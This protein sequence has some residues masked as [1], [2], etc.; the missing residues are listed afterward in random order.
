M[1]EPFNSTNNTKQSSFSDPFSL[2]AHF[3]PKQAIATPLKGVSLEVSSY[4]PSVVV[5]FD[6]LT[7][8]QGG[9][10]AAKAGKAAAPAGRG[11]A[12]QA[13]RAATKAASKAVAD[14]LKPGQDISLLEGLK[15]FL[16]VNPS[17]S[18]LAPMVGF[19][20][21]LNKFSSLQ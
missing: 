15:T 13:G 6:V 17:L 4:P 11:L 19:A 1:A 18:F 14:A 5:M 9:G 21:L 12:A 16:A 7:L 3:W 10:A 8:L 20:E 2:S